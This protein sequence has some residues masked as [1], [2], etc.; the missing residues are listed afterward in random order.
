[1][2]FISLC[3]YYVVIYDNTIRTVEFVAILAIGALCGILGKQI[4]EFKNNK[5]ES[6]SDNE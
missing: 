3:S 2:L 4:E 6:I 5:K 1:M